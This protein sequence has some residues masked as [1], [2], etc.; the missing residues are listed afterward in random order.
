MAATRAQ[1]AA[2]HGLANGTVDQLWV[3]REEN[4]HPEPVKTVDRTMYWDPDEWDAWYAGFKKRA[5]RTELHIDRSG[6]PDDLIT[7]SEAARVLGVEPSSITRYPKRPPRGWPQPVLYE[8][9]PSGRM[10]RRYRRADIWGYADTR[11]MAGPCAKRT[12]TSPSGQR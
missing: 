2:G 12:T 5:Q 4:G 6:S 11:T 9:L 7:L 3:R 8:R 1:L 10:R